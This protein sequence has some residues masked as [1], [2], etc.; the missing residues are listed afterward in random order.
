MCDQKKEKYLIKSGEKKHTQFKTLSDNFYNMHTCIL[1]GLG[2][3][4]WL[5]I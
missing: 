2:N 4:E 5:M 1:L 3:V